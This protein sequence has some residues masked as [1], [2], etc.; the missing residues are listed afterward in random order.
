V[1][2]LR[3]G[4]SASGS[5]VEA[6]VK[7]MRREASAAGGDGRLSRRAS[8][9]ETRVGEDGRGGE[10]GGR[11]AG[12]RTTVGFARRG[13]REDGAVS[14]QG[15]EEARAGGRDSPR[16]RGGGGGWFRGGGGGI[17]RGVAVGVVAGFAAGEAERRV[18]F[19]GGGSLHC[20][21]NS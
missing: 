5:R 8:A 2:I 12:R 18:G 9:D 20:P 6:D 19:A 7:E 13:S 15:R 17:R 10:E 21:L 14:R 11:E 4:A 3:A 16:G 1:R